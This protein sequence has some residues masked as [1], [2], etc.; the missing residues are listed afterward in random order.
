MSTEPT[1]NSP[2]IEPKVID[3]EV[4]RQYEQFLKAN[5][6]LNLEDDEF[7]PATGPIKLTEDSI[8][9]RSW[10]DDTDPTLLADKDALFKKIRAL[11]KKARKEEP[12]VD[13]EE[14][15]HRIDDE[16]GAGSLTCK[17]LIVDVGLKRIV[18]YDG[19]G[20]KHLCCEACKQA[21]VPGDIPSLGAPM[22]YPNIPASIYRTVMIRVAMVLRVSTSRIATGLISTMTIM[23]PF[24]MISAQALITSSKRYWIGRLKTQP[25]KR[26]MTA[27]TR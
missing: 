17:E 23:D 7:Y 2:S 24:A 12:D 15:L 26:S 13:D 19:A 18:N 9:Y 6:E 4:L 10:M 25:S 22:I 3:P 5:P 20:Y 27:L 8:R 21:G 11:I 1:E 16:Y 14:L